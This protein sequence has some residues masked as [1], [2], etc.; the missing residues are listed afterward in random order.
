MMISALII[1]LLVWCIPMVLYIVWK[2]GDWYLFLFPMILSFVICVVLTVISDVLSIG[3]AIMVVIY[4]IY[5]LTNKN[6]RRI[7]NEVKKERECIYEEYKKEEVDNQVTFKNYIL[8]SGNKVEY[9]DFNTK[10]IYILRPYVEDIDKKYKRQIQK[11]LNELEEVY[12][13]NWKCFID[14]Y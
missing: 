1:L 9:I 4:S 11:Y 7:R 13:G 12:G 2:R 5:S 10:T 14:T 8:P 3:F 6:A